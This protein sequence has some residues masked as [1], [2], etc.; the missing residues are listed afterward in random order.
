MD[1]CE[2]VAYVTEIVDKAIP[3]VEYE[4]RKISDKRLTLFY[5]KDE[6]KTVKWNREYVEKFNAILDK[7]EVELKNKIDKLRA[8]TYAKLYEYLVEYGQGTIA[9]SDAVRMVECLF[10][11]DYCFNRG[12]FTTITQC[13]DIVDLFIEHYKERVKCL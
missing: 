10:G 12:V 3:K 1:K 11:D 7:R 5:V 2:L 6:N 4:W 13:E 8:N 9:Y